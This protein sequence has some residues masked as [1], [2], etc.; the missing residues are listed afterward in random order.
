LTGKPKRDVEDTIM[1][2]GRSGPKGITLEELNKQM[3][4]LRSEVH[5]S[6]PE[7]TDKKRSK[8][9]AAAIVKRPDLL[10]AVCDHFQEMGL[11][12]PK[13]G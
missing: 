2:E 9:L 3:A 12:A 7:A 13:R 11:R 4:D 1:A 10:V 6:N 8:L 5:R